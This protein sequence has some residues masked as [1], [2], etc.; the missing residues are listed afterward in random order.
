MIKLILIVLLSIVQCNAGLK[1]KLGMDLTA[2]E[3]ELFYDLMKNFS[4]RSLSNYVL[5]KDNSKPF[6]FTIVGDR[7]SN[8][9]TQDNQKKKKIDGVDYRIIKE[10][11]EPSK[12]VFLAQYASNS[13]QFREI[14]PGTIIKT[15]ITEETYNRRSKVTRKNQRQIVGVYGIRRNEKG[16]EHFISEQLPDGAI[17]H[18]L[19]SEQEIVIDETKYITY[20]VQVTSSFKAVDQKLYNDV[21]GGLLKLSAMQRKEF[22]QTLLAM[23][24]GLSDDV[25]VM[26]NSVN[27]SMRMG[28]QKYNKSELINDIIRNLKDDPKKRYPVLVKF[29]D[30]LDVYD[31]KNFS[32]KDLDT[33]LKLITFLKTVFFI[34][35]G[36]LND[37]LN[38]LMSF[39]DNTLYGKTLPLKDKISLIVSEPINNSNDFRNFFALLRG[40]TILKYEEDTRQQQVHAVGKLIHYVK[41]IINGNHER[42]GNT[43]IPAKTID[44][45]AAA[46]RNEWKR[47]QD[48][49]DK[50]PLP[51]NNAIA[52][53]LNTVIQKNNNNAAKKKKV[54]DPERANPDDMEAIDEKFSGDAAFE[55]WKEE[56]EA[57]QKK[58]KRK[59]ARSKKIKTEFD[60]ERADVNNM[61]TLEEKFGDDAAF[62]EWKEETEAAQKAIKAKQQHIAQEKATV[63]AVVQSNDAGAEDLDSIST[64]NLPAELK[65]QIEE[66]QEELEEAEEE[67]A[68]HDAAVKHHKKETQEVAKVDNVANDP[69]INTDDLEELN[70]KATSPKVK[71]IIEQEIE[72][73]EEKES[74]TKPKTPH[75]KS[76]KTERR[77]GDDED[78]TNNEDD[79]NDDGD[80][81][82]RANKEF[83]LGKRK[84]NQSKIGKPRSEMTREEKTADNR[85]RR[86]RQKEN[87]HRRTARVQI[88]GGE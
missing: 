27:S 28:S 42:Y 7:F 15:T 54:F 85:E 8:V 45:Q 78:F 60:P 56:I 46:I 83:S 14:Q 4:D 30:F 18:K 26:R 62:E 67:Q 82:S 2:D 44:G 5:K 12:D 40:V 41:G 38:L 6:H 25:W 63:S 73:R 86:Q 36:D 23:L 49:M 57:A 65:R 35:R 48:N 17:K 75:S 31:W 24:D 51:E 59:H 29:F 22:M 72:A 77:S 1:A 81:D 66:K 9:L 70:N 64:Q 13:Q 61:D 71:E 80:E 3:K 55:E 76:Q 52:A 47:L 32:K 21:K 58:K 87:K 10:N 53:L 34:K 74:V 16:V 79:D 69:D 50:E 84:S 11:T 88:A 19:D 33:K 39:Y 20:A 43:K 37:Y 68:R